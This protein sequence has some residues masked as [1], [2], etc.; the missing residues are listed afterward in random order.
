VFVTAL[1]THLTSDKG[2]ANKLG[3]A[4]DFMREKINSWQ[5]ILSKRKEAAAEFHD[6]E[7]SGGKGGG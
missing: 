5:D 4:R 3:P 7:R 6:L 2:E 1:Y